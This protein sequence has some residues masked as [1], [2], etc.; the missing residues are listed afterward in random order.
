LNKSI[1]IDDYIYSDEIDTA[2]YKVLSEKVREVEKLVNPFK[3]R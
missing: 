2:T 1:E 3:L